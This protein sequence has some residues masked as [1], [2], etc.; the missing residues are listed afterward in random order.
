[1]ARTKNKT[2]VYASHYTISR[3]NFCDWLSVVTV[4]GIMLISSSFISSSFLFSSLYLFPSIPNY[5][6]IFRP[7][8]PRSC[9]VHQT[10]LIHNATFPRVRFTNTGI[11]SVW[12]AEVARRLVTRNADSNAHFKFPH[13]YH[14]CTTVPRTVTG[15]NRSKPTSAYTL[16]EQRLHLHVLQSVCRLHTLN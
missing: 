16:P 7:F 2:A 14:C 12:T 10:H 1:M 9:H 3:A 13:L 11:E 8:V 6:L 5:S 15:C 4:G